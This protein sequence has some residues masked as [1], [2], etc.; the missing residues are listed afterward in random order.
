MSIRAK[1]S[2]A[3]GC[4]FGTIVIA[5]A[6]ASYI[7]ERAYAYQR[8]DAALQVAS[9]ATAMS[10]EH[11]LNEHST[12]AAGERDL[13]SVLN[14]SNSFALTDTEIQVCDGGRVAASRSAPQY[15]VNLCDSQGRAPRWNTSLPSV[16][17]TDVQLSVPKFGVTYKIYAAK[18]A[19]PVVTQLAHIR[20]ALLIGVP[21][22]FALAGFVGYS[23]AKRY[24][25][26]LEELLQ[27][28]DSLSSSDLS[29][30]V[31][32]SNDKD[33]VG[34]LGTGFNRLLDR[35]EE[36]FSLLRRFMADAGHQIRTPVTVSLAAA[37][38]TTR[39]PTTGLQDCKE[40]L[41]IVE[42]Q[43]LQLRHIVEDMFFLA[44]ADSA[45]LSVEMC[46]VFL[47]DV[48]SDAVRSI[49]PLASAKQQTIRLNSLPEAKCLGDEELLRQAV[50]VL[51]D[52]AVK[53]AAAGGTIQVAVFEQGYNW[54]C[55]VCD[56]GPGIPPAAQPHIFERFFRQPPNAEKSSGAGLGLSI[57]KAITEKHSG[58]I[59]LRESAPG[60][61]VFEIAIPALASN[62]TAEAV[63]AN[64]L[65]VSI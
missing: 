41:R 62:A 23:L 26:P 14:E 60:K 12:R 11:E 10:A 39:D 18:P 36:A 53:Y 51:L 59:R 38:V 55:S 27:T 54:A 16:R 2:I 48:V 34:R 20:F 40:S 63:Q 50:V 5:L 42:Q 21:V 1:L 32:V 33:D 56:N 45:S 17:V 47:D 9:G 6:L 7:V 64:S 25:R 31:N 43:M 57:A 4:L 58:V 49:R 35:L 24:L 15:K 28:I 3:F 37:Q 30:R 19:F 61:T 22:G 8:L 44:Q 65:A 46:E 29:A 52:N 13:Q